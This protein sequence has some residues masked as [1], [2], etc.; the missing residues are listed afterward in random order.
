MPTDYPTTLTEHDCGHW[1]TVRCP[2][3]H[4][5]TC[6]PNATGQYDLALTARLARDHCSAKPLFTN[7][8]IRSHGPRAQLREVP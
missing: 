4:A 6:V 5:F 1:G 2:C 8:E 3:G 7:D